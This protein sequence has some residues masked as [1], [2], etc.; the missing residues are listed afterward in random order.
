MIARALVFCAKTDAI[1]AV[2]VLQKSRVGGATR[3]LTIVST[4][5]VPGL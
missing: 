2:L 5:G 3:H 1:I 4:V